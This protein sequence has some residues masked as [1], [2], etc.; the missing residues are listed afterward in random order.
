MRG[1]FQVGQ[2]LIQYK[3]EKHIF[4]LNYIK[5]A[6]ILP[7]AYYNDK[8]Y[9]LLGRETVDVDHKAKGKWSDF[10]GS[11]EKGETLNRL[12]GVSTKEQI[13]KLYNG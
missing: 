12:V 8:I 11:I 10:G 6:G 3:I 13:L 1:Q 7:L 4:I 9:F 5:M 2:Y